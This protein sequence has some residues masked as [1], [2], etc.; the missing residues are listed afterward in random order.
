MTVVASASVAETETSAVALAYYAHLIGV[1]ECAFWGV[2]AG[3]SPAYAC[4]QIWS[5]HD[6]NL[7][8]HYLAEAQTELENVLGYPI[9]ARWIVSEQQRYKPLVLTRWGYVQAVGVR[10]EAVIASDEPVDHTNDPAVIGP[11]ATTVTDPDEV[12]IY[13]AGTTQ[14]ITPSAVEIAGGMLLIT[15]PRCRLVLPAYADNPETGWDYTDTTV[16]GPFAQLVD[17]KQVYNDSSTQGTL[18][19][20]PGC[21][22][23]TTP[24]AETTQTACLTVREPIAGTLSVRPATYSDGTWVVACALGVPDY[25]RLN[26]LAGVTADAQLLEMIIRLAHAKMPETP[27]GCAEGKRLWERDRHVPEVLT[28]ERLNCPFGF[29][30]GAWLAWRFAQARRLVRG[31]LL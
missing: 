17:I 26:Y 6:R 18:V 4:R 20:M 30:D 25:V 5:L 12:H 10:A 14:E 3:T 1:D 11:L 13:H 31:I 8:A 2:N 7:I 21:L 15:V 24:C 29:S 27:C 28:A 23:T 22:C 9:G 16:T 19:Y